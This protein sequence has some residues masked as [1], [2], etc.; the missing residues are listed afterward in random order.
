MS[1]T[2][3]ATCLKVN[4]VTVSVFNTATLCVPTIC[5]PETCV[6]NHKWHAGCTQAGAIV[7]TH[8]TA[9]LILHWSSRSEMGHML[10]PQAPAVKWCSAAGS[11]VL[12]TGRS[13]KMSLCSLQCQLVISVHAGAVSTEDCAQNIA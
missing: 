10:R 12:L 11:V 5:L 4:C 3:H 6:A 9:D 8:G 1:T 13:A 2:G 7:S